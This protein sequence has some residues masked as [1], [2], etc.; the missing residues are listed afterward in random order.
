MRQTT[1]PLAL[2]LAA[3]TTGPLNGTTYS[4]AT[5]AG[6][7]F[8]FEGYVDHPNELISVQVLSS[9]TADPTLDSS[10][11]QIATAHS[12]T[13]PITLSADPSN[14]LYAWTV[15][16]VPAPTGFAGWPLGGVLRTRGVSTDPTNGNTR[17]LTT[18]DAPTFSQ[19]FGAA[20]A[21]GETWSAIGTNC[22]GLGYGMVALVSTGKT[23]LALPSNQRPDWLGY[24]SDSTTSATE[25]YYQ[26]WNAPANLTA[27]KQAYGFTSSDPT[28]TYYNDGDLGIGREM[29]CHGGANGSVACY[30]TNYSANGTAEFG[31]DPA[32]VLANAIAHTDKFA[33]VAMVFT[34]PANT[35]NS[36][37]FV[38]YGADD[39][40]SDTARLDTAGVH[41]SVP[42]NCLECHGIDSLFLG[43]QVNANAKFLPFDPYSYKYS[44]QSS[45]TLDAQQEQFRK[46]NA[47]VSQTSLTTAENDFLA[48]LYAPN[49]VTTPGAFANDSYVPSGWQS[50]QGQALQSTYLGIV[51]VGCRTCH[52][53]ATNPALDF[54]SSDD[55]SPT[56]VTTIRKYL[57]Q[58]AAASGSVKHPMPQAE[59]TTQKL[60]ESGARGLLVTGWTGSDGFDACVP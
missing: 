32:T 25:A 11:A 23:P 55:W 28:A 46:L 51:K 58:P 33:T 59:R 4:G 56:T 38:V 8:T 37:K 35:P 45:Y 15:T 20:Y 47:L 13:N 50:S 17:I 9:P 60:W 52:M 43:G 1:V 26:S 44:T 14:P 36:V 19:C 27:F 18:F 10:W 49:S 12:S 53:S 7:S 34:Q 42:N 3:C 39:N 29:H 41:T 30:V 22:T 6:A 16:A 57:C 48:G 54:M 21:A 2:F 40:R 5:T 24:K 31:D